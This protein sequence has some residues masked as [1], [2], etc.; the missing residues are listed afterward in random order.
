MNETNIVWGGAS[1]CRLTFFSIQIAQ[2]TSMNLKNSSPA[3]E[4]D[5]GLTNNSHCAY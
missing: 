1:S 3:K 2:Y 4:G 5:P